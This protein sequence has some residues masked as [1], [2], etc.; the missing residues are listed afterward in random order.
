MFFKILKFSVFA[1]YNTNR[2]LLFAFNPERRCL[3]ILFFVWYP[4]MYSFSVH[5]VVFVELKIV[6]CQSLSSC[7]LLYLPRR[8]MTWTIV[9]PCPGNGGGGIFTHRCSFSRKSPTK[10]WIKIVSFRGIV[11]D[12]F[13]FLTPLSVSLYLLSVLRGRS[14]SNVHQTGFPTMN[15]CEATI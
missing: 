13:G 12:P 10:Q 2:S 15:A 7:T 6:F 1:I 4:N 14:A 5:N 9:N 3:R 11:T 8:Y